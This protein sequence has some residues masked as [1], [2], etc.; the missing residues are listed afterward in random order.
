MPIT[1]KNLP[2]HE[3]IGLEVKVVDSTDE[4]LVGINGEVLDET[5]S[6]LRIEDKKVEKKTCI[7][8]FRLPDGK[9][10]KINGKLIAKRPEDRVGMKLPRK[11]DFC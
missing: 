5:Q 7:F 6:L 11:W 8:E 4:S 2:K 1:P 3:L 10:V 9:K